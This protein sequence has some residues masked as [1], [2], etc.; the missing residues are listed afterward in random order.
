MKKL[1][2]T[3]LFVLLLLGGILANAAEVEVDFTQKDVLTKNLPLQLRGK[4]F[5][6]KRA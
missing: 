2:S 1:F 5:S 6:L 4:P 3:A